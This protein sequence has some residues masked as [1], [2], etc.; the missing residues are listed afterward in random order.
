MLQTIFLYLTIQGS[1][2][3]VQQSGCLSFVAIG[4]AQH[5]LDVQPLYGGKMK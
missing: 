1:K 3:Y 5:F 4:I 2:P